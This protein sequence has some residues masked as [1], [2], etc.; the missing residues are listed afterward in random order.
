MQAV[1]IAAGESSRFWPFNN[2][3]H[4]SQLKLL[5]KSLL[6]WT[7]KGL[8]SHGVK[9]AAIVHSPFSSIQ[10]MLAEEGSGGIER[11]EYYTQDQP[12]GTGNALWQAREFVQE[13]FFVCWPGKINA[14]DIVPKVLEQKNNGAQA[15]LAGAR[16][17]T[18]WDYGIVRFEGDK[19]V[20]IVENPARGSEP[21]N[22]KTIGFYYFEPDFF[23][24]YEKLSSRHEADFI[25]AINLYL[26][27]KRG[28]LV[29]LE[30]DA[31]TLKYPWQAFEILDTL[32]RS[33]F[34]ERLIAPSAMIGRNVTIEGLVHIGERAVIKSGTAIEGPCFIGDDCEIGYNNV[35]RGGSNLER[36]VKT[37]AF[38]EIKHS[39]V[40]QDTHFHSGYVGDSIIGKNCRFGAG[41]ITANRRMDRSSI[42]SMVKGKK[43]DTGLTF[44][45]S[46]IGD[47]VHSGI[48]T[49]TMPGVF[50][51][52]KAMI[53]P[54]TNVFEN[55]QD[56]TILYSNPSLVQKQ[57]LP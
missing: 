16:T 21:S 27:E 6:H 39:I 14:R 45:G 24:Y 25:D 37:G 28:A 40:Q 11:I 43:I 54:G 8:A 30:H 1:I 49:G 10:E 56:E 34:F 36:G 18:P 22:I 15:V 32:L 48:H 2:G 7:L 47:G 41:F 35:I 42:H 13:P 12:A 53:G 3:R 31:P 51:G 50:I 44:F 5:G 29:F 46:A 26:K 57:N 33:S 52:R 19:A 17:E 23:G 55:V 20:E 38:C 4:K 9:S